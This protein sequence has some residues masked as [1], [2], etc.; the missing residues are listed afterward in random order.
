MDLLRR[1]DLQ[2]LASVKNGPCASIYMPTH[3][4]GAETRQDPI[5]LKNL[6]KEAEQQLELAGVRSVEA[7]EILLP[8]QEL[9]DNFD[10][11]QHQ[12]DGL[13][14]FA[15]R[16]R[17]RTCRVP[18]SFREFV[19]VTGR[20]HL[21]PLLPLFT[22]DGPFYVLAISGNQVRMLHCSRFGAHERELPASV[23]KSRAEAL[24]YVDAEAQLQFHTRTPQGHGMRGGMFFGT[25]AGAGD[26]ETKQRIKEYFLAIARGLHEIL[27]DDRTPMVFAGVD[28]LFPIYREVNSY[29]HLL[30]TS[31]TGNP[32][33]LSDKELHERA[34]EVVEPHFRTIQRE[35]AGAYPEAASA[36]RASNEVRDVAPAAFQ[37]RVDT[38]FVAVGQQS[39][40]TFDEATQSVHLDGEPKPD[41]VDLLDFAAIQTLRHGGKVY[42]V[43]PA[44]VPGGT[45][46]A[47]LY[48]Y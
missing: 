40:G 13:A 8:V 23:P 48:R 1:E 34:W 39:W 19:R 4:M 31:I 27:H 20:F 10:F 17:F 21:K 3:R 45:L 6:L 7:R 11:W 37:G 43:N 36:A 28:Y 25:G 9:I 30:D 41:N 2:E 22:A 38:L 44:E 18:I 29:P 46:L 32:D 15:A 33:E 5:R 35:A 16:D 47:A 26:E 24:K 42:A 12:S 14:L